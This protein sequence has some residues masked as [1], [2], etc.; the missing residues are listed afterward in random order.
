MK[1]IFNIL[2]L[3]IITIIFNS[4]NECPLIEAPAYYLCETRIVT[5]ERFNPNYTVSPGP[6][7]E[8]PIIN[9]D[10]DYNIGMFEFPV[11]NQSSG[12]FPNDF[13]FKNNAKIPVVSLP[14]EINNV[15]YYLAIQ[16][17]Y[18]TNSEL[19]GDILVTDVNL[20][21]ND[22]SAQVRVSGSIARIN[23]NFVTEDAQVFCDYV[24]NNTQTFEDEFKNM[25]KENIFGSNFPLGDLF[26][27]NYNNSQVLILND[28][29]ELVGNYGAP[30]VPIPFV[31][32]INSF[33]LLK[34]TSNS[35]NL[36]VRTG[37]MFVYISKNGK[38][39]VFLIAEIRAS[40]I[41]PLRRRMSIMFFNVDK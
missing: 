4:C 6:T 3:I 36:R 16:D 7:P 28:K 9:L 29:L 30:D 2:I 38:R 24:K 8:E 15:K 17:N 10:P 32:I 12:N 22:V 19:I 33:N 41:P 20:V 14:F 35:Y 23:R 11:N 40:T 25:N 27:S 13:R 26:V 5:I 31:N 37:D 39:F 18:P 34:A 1:S 21:P